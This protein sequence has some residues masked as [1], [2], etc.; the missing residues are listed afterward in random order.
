MAS[1]DAAERVGE[2]EFAALYAAVEPGLRRGL[3]AAYGPE[4][5]REATADALSWAWEH[6]DRVGR[7][8]H[9]LSFLYRVGQ[10]SVRRRRQRVV[11]A[12]GEWDEPWVEPGLARGLAG[13]SERQR[14]AVMLVHGY[15]WTLEEVAAL[16]GVR[17]TTVQNHL[18]RGLARLRDRLKVGDDG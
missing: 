8:Q 3:M 11:H 1:T 15:G 4:L 10:S 13:L 9:P 7:M 17:K 18:E 5:G 12:R 14:V 6:R 2:A 16:L